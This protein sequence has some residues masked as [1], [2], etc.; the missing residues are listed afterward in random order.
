M[1]KTDTQMTF[2]TTSEFKKRV[3]RQAQKERR[4]IS[5]LI[6]KVLE[7]YLEMQEKESE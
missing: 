1:A 3:E 2:R 7:E 4:P 5:N 6:I